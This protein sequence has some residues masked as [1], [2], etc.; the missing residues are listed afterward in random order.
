MTDE[1]ERIAALEVQ[2]ATL[3]A[4]IDLLTSFLLAAIVRTASEEVSQTLRSEIERKIR[5]ANKSMQLDTLADLQNLLR[6]FDTALPA[7]GK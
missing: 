7:R 3:T 6:A 5:V 1:Q 4:K 2:V